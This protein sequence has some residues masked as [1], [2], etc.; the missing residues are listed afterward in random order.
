MSAQ[1]VEQDFGGVRRIELPLPFR[2]GY[3][4]VYLV[5]LEDG[6]IL[7]DCG[8]DL[9]DVTSAYEKAGI[10]WSSIRQT[11]ITHSHPDHS[12]FAERIRRLTGAPVRMHHHEDAFLNTM[13]TPTEYLAWQEEVLR[14]AGVPESALG[15]IWKSCLQMNSFFPAISADSYIEDGEIIPTA[16]GPMQALLTPGHTRGHL[17]FHLPDAKILIAGDQ[18]LNPR[19]PH[20]EWDSETDALAEFRVSLE[21]LQQLD[22]EWVLPS[23]GR[24]SSGREARIRALLEHSREMAGQ[25]ARLQ[26][27]GSC[28]PHEL[29]LAFWKRPMSAFEHRNAV[30]EMLAYLE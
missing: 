4:N 6:W 26:S 24:P 5:P 9:P 20:L 7:V 21:R 16:L 13:R 14:R 8:M 10:D 29:A 1:A 25:I 15:G 30:F 17:C 18:I 3:V 23:H 2:P 22:P 11:L 28:S 27:E 12:G 19:T